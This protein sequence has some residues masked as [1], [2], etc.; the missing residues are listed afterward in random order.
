VVTGEW[1]G[2]GGGQVGLVTYQAGVESAS[3]LEGHYLGIG[4]ALSCETD[5]VDPSELGGAGFARL[6]ILMKLGRHTYRD[7]GK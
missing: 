5:L 3:S 1:V 4:L 6:S 2:V 7:E